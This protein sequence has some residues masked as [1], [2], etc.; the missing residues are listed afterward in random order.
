M[1]IEE[2]TTHKVMSQFGLYQVSL[3]SFGGSA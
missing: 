1:Y 3:D 2:Y